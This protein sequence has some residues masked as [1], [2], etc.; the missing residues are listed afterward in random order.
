MTNALTM[1]QALAPEVV[2]AAT[3]FLVMGLDLRRNPN[4]RAQATV[5]IWGLLAGALATIP[6][7]L[8][9]A[10]SDSA[11]TLWGGIFLADPLSVV[12]RALACVTGALVLL[13]SIDPVDAER[14]N[15]GDFVTLVPFV[16]LGL[17]LSVSAGELLTFFVAFEI[18]SLPLYLMAAWNRNE[19]ASAE[20]GI[21]YFVTGSVS[22]AVML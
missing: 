17:M 19:R 10:A 21:K 18:V 4:P 14:R 16:V 6:D 1:L 15:P 20:A 5:A 7:W 8:D 9:T 2:V 3:A 12:F 13:F 11:L 22:S